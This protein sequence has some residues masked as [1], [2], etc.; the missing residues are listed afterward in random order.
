MKRV[1]CPLDIVVNDFIISHSQSQSQSQKVYWSTTR[2]GSYQLQHKT[3]TKKKD[4]EAERKMQC[5]DIYIRNIH[6]GQP[7]AI[8]PIHIR[9]LYSYDIRASLLIL[10]LHSIH[11]R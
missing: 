6:D 5:T 1:F 3:N 10:Y 8:S 11:V 2:N 7:A 4:N 9:A